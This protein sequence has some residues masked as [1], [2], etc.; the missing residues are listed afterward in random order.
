MTL[1]VLISKY[2]KF[3]FDYCIKKNYL[4]L[5]NTHWNEHL[6]QN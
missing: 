2:L 5:I 1:L 6:E 3:S 4:I